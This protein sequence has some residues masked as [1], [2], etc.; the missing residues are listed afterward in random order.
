MIDIYII[1]I[2]LVFWGIG[3]FILKN[4]IETFFSNLTKGDCNDCGCKDCHNQTEIFINKST[5][6]IESEIIKINKD[7]SNKIRKD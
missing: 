6:D 1:L 4:K 2:I 5:N 3:I 7:I